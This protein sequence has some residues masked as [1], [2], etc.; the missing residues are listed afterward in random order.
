M[1]GT[2]AVVTGATRGIGAAVAH[3]FG[4]AGA[5]VVVC[6]RNGDDVTELVE[7]L[8]GDGASATGHRADVRDEFDLERL[9][10]TAARE[11][12]PI[13]VVV[14]NAGVYHGPAGETPLSSESY[15]AFDETLATNARGVFATVKEAIPHMADDARVLIPTGSVARV[16]KEG[17]GAYAVS[18]AAAEGVMR[19]FA[20]ELP[21]SVGCLEPGQVATDLTGNQ[22]RDPES[23][24][25][26]FRWAA[27]D[28]D[29]A[30]LDGNVLTLKEWKRA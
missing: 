12:G 17:Y 3:V 27:V 13:D 10:E 11:F 8:R 30:E 2:T 5:N 4:E 18:R 19:G 24:A 26:M 21:Q 23:V 22:G 25:G 7:E 9:M 1:D 20:A 28:V 14:A 29:P 15:T 16:G 6:A